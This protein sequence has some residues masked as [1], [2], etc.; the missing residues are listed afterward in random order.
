MS[1]LK[2]MVVV[3]TGPESTGKTTLAQCITDKFRF[4]LV[5]EVSR[6]IL[7][8]SNG[9]YDYNTITTIAMEQWRHQ[10]D[11]IEKCDRVC[12]DTDLLT[13]IIWAEVKYRRSEA[14]WKS[15]WF[16]SS[17]DLFFLCKPDIEWEY[18]PLR[19]NPHDRDV[20]F[21]RYIEYLDMHPAP[22]FIIKGEGNVRTE[23]AFHIID[24]VLHA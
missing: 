18:D 15:T 19:E 8:L 11:A 3:I 17:V 16:S 9:V 21:N 5:P 4:C 1:N 7:M 2:D 6:D 22:Y 23:K 20:L 14:W 13:N 12:C 10:C 24:R